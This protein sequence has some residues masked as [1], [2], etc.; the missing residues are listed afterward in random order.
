LV[1]FLS[2]ISHIGFISH[3]H[4]KEIFL[5]FKTQ[6]FFKS[7]NNI[8]V[9]EAYVLY[10][11]VSFKQLYVNQLNKCV[12]GGES[13]P[14]SNHHQ[15]SSK[16]IVVQRAFDDISL[17]SYTIHFG[18]EEEATFMWIDTWMGEGGGGGGGRVV[19]NKKKQDLLLY[20]FISFEGK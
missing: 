13:Y 17:A 4:K 1:N 10:I 9:E 5:A 20:S 19:Y 11:D 7:I 12:G 16:L 18:L 14:F 8:T 6:C 15:P 2:Q 3:N